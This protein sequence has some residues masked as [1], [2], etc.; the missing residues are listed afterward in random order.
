MENYFLGNKVI[1]KTDQRSLQ[2]LGSQRLLEGIQHKLMLKLLEF[3]YSIQYKKGK[4]NTVA[5]A[6]S[7]QFQEEDT[8]QNQPLDQCNSVSVLV[9]T[10]QSKVIDSYTQD[11]HCTKLLQ[12]LAINKDSHPYF[13]L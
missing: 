7:R 8:S 13:T 5:D 10:W 6:L 2:Y 9:P 1:I 3:D 12:E 4:E 11:A